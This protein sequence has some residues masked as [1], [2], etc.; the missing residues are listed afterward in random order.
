MRKTLLI[1]LTV[2]FLVSCDNSAATV[3]DDYG[4]SKL[5]VDFGDNEA[6]EIGANVDGMPI[7]QDAKKALEQAKLDY[8]DGFD[9]IAVEFDLEPISNQNFNDNKKLG[10]QTTG[11]DRNVNQQSAEISSFFEIYENSFK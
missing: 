3:V 9:A 8:K 11:R 2:I 7:F 5:N 1:I 10:W 6:Y 4:V